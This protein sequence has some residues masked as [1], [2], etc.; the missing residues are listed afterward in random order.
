MS[1]AVVVWDLAAKIDHMYE[2]ICAHSLTH[3]SH[4]KELPLCHFPNHH[5]NASQTMTDTAK[6]AQKKGNVQS[7]GSF[8]KAKPRVGRPAKYP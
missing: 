2:E 6:E 4:A 1:R 3:Y 7:I 5:H 8:F